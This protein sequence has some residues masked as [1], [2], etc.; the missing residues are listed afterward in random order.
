MNFLWPRSPTPSPS[1]L[2]R[3]GRVIHWT[4]TGIAALSAVACVWSGIA[5]LFSKS[6][7][8]PDFGAAIVAAI[9][10]ALFFLAGRAAR[11]V[12]SGE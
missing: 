2:N 5:E 11:Y 10:F 9:V 6:E 3:F 8:G 4:F 1:A 12:L 7:Y